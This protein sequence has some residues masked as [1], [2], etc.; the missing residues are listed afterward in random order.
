M[1]TRH[2][3][4]TPT[5]PA[6]VDYPSFFRTA[7][8][9]LPAWT[10]PDGLAASADDVAAISPRLT[11]I[12]F[13]QD[14]AYAALWAA[15][16]EDIRHGSWARVSKLLSLDGVAQTDRRE[17]AAENDMVRCLPLPPL[18]PDPLMLIISSRCGSF[19]GKKFE[20]TNFE[21]YYGCFCPAAKGYPYP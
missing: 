17:Y 11:A 13:G 1:S 6:E 4:A 9:I 8:A 3:D 7:A 10:L 19:S 21:L 14:K 12:S 18:S 15:M 2:G 5:A 16:L 20:S